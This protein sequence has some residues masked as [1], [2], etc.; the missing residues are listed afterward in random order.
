MAAW[1]YK[2][3]PDEYLLS[4]LSTD[5]VLALMGKRN[6]KKK[7]KTKER[8]SHRLY[9]NVGGVVSIRGTWHR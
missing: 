1:F 8:E 9:R 5:K 6:K 2:Q 7:G 3:V 4:E